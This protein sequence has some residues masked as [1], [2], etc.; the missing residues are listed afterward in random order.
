VTDALPVAPPLQA[1]LVCDALAAIAD[2]S[3]I[4]KFLVAEH[5]LASSIVTV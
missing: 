3:V 1:I 2:G 5:P 4:V